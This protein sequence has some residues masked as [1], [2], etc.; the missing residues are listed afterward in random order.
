MRVLILE[1]C[2]EH[3][4]LCL[5]RVRNKD[6]SCCAKITHA[7]ATK[8]PAVLPLNISVGIPQALWIGICQSWHL[9]SFFGSKRLLGHMQPSPQE[10]MLHVA[11]GWG[12]CNQFYNHWRAQQEWSLL[13]THVS[14]KKM[15]VLKQDSRIR[16]L[17]DGEKF[18]LWDS[19]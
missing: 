13:L 12:G 16:T 8:Y 14:H 7:A 5:T 19:W 17:I 9:K 2:L 18:F 3:K 1:S 10:G 11:S 4:F 6:H 15:C